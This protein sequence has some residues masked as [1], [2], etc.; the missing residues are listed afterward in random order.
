MIMQSCWGRG[1]P[2]YSVED[3]RWTNAAVS[4]PVFIKGILELLH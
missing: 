4:S 1:P 2:Q 3:H